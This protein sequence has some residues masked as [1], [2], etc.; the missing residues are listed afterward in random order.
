MAQNA[1]KVALNLGCGFQKLPGMVNVDAFEN[2]EPDIKWDLNNFPYPW[3]DNSIHAIFAAHI[4]EHLDDWWGALKECARILVPG[5]TL[6]IRVPDE[7][8][9]TAG[10]YRDHNH[11]FSGVSFHG[12]IGAS[13]GTNAWAKTEQETVPLEMVSHH[14]V[15]FKKYN[16]MRHVPGLLGF[17]ANHMRNFIWEQRFIFIKR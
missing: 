2:C 9:T 8:S 1:Q 3:E 6:E 7:S 4:F 17:C 15:P 10:T 13:H 5:G 14:H 16:W 12:V 11:I